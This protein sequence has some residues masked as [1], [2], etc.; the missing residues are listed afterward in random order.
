MKC[1]FSTV[2]EFWANISIQE[3]K[4]GLFDVSHMGQITLRG[5]SYQE[6]ALALEKAIPMDVLSLKVGRQRYGFLTTD[7]GGIWMI[8]V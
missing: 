2:W 1:Q 5:S 3:Q 8:N 6:T 4:A 7:G